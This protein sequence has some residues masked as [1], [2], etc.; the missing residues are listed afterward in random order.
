MSRT[1]VR[2]TAALLCGVVLVALGLAFMGLPDTAHAPESL[3]VDVDFDTFQ[4]GVTQ[5]R[6]S[7]VEVPVPSQVAEARVDAVGSAMSVDVELTICQADDCQPLE[8]GTELAPGPYTLTVS[9]TLDE[10][11]TPGSSGE[12]AGQIR[13]VETRRTNAVDTSLLMTIAAIGLAA[14]AIG[15]LAVRQRHGVAS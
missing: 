3:S 8:A 5:T 15:A 14:I 11:V 7:M 6:T 1:A 9:A 12:L 2:A 4:P 10:Q 13:I